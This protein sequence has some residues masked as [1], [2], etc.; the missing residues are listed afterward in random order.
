MS[1]I[2]II[3]P[4]YNVEKYLSECVDSVLSQSFYE[5][6]LLLIDDGSTDGSGTICD[7]YAMRDSR[8]RVFHKVNGGLSSARNYGIDRANGDYIIFL[9]S[10]DYWNNSDVLSYLYEIIKRFDADVV[11]GEYISID[12]EGNEILTLP[13]NKKDIELEILDSAAFYK[14]AIAGEN[15]SWLYL[16]KRDSLNEFRFDESCKFQEDIDFNIKYYSQ[17]HKCVYTSR[18]FYVYR[19]RRNSIVTTLKIE[20][21]EGSFSLCDVFDEYSTLVSDEE[22][23]TI[24]RYNSIMMYY[25]T[26]E[27]MSQ[28]PYYKERLNI[29]KRLSLVNRNKKIRKWA[30][31]TNKI[32]PLPIY[33][34]PLMGVYYFRMRFIVGSVLRKLRI[35]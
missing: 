5:M 20:N 2:S 17:N 30:M 32:Y 35:K 15:F 24:Y 21:L 18:Q 12:E 4:V 14:R 19:K 8:V 6:E 10:D 7:E 13:R 34:S 31:T 27:T 11:R 26:L 28:E 29:I 22:L 25:W 23:K 9:D 16:F 1:I 33:I 3:V